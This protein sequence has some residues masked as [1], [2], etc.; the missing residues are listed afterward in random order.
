MHRRMEG[1]NLGNR[2]VSRELIGLGIGI[3]EQHQEAG[4]SQETLVE[5][6]GISAN[7][8]S[9]IEG[10]LMAMS[11]ETFRKLVRA[12]EADV[13]ELLGHAGF[14]KKGEGGIREIFSRISHMEQQKRE[15]VVQTVKALVDALE[16][17]RRGI[18]RRG[19]LFSGL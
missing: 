12:L 19:Y 8:V 17:N 2:A 10:G 13:G 7:T 15:I 11:V 1:R 18:Y 6:A 9:R 4:M 5:K 14:T 16:E 3:K